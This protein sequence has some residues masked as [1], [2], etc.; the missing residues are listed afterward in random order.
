MFRRNHTID[1][2]GSMQNSVVTRGNDYLI[3][4]FILA[5]FYV[6]YRYPFKINDETQSSGYSE[7]PQFLKLGK[8]F[9]AGGILIFWSFYHMVTAPAHRTTMRN[10]LLAVLY[11][12]LAVCAVATSIATNEVRLGQVAVFLLIP[13]V[14]HLLDF[15]G[16]DVR[17]LY[18]LLRFVSVFALLFNVFIIVLY[19]TTG[20]LPALAYRGTVSIRFGSYLDDPNGFGIMLSCLIPFSWFAFRGIWKYLMVIGL[21]ASLPITQSLSGIIGTALAIIVFVSVRAMTN[22]TV[23]RI[24]LISGFAV[25]A[26]IVTVEWE[27]ITYDPMI[28]DLFR[29]KQG[30]MDVHRGDFDK[31]FEVKPAAWLGMDPTGELSETNYAE[32]LQ[33][34]GALFVL[35]AVG[36]RIYVGQRFAREM[37]RPDVP[38]YCLAVWSGLFCYIVCNLFGGFT[39]P[40]DRSFPTNMLLVL[41]TTVGTIGKFSYSTATSAEVTA[42]IAEPQLVRSRFSRRPYPGLVTR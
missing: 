39:L 7:T 11:G 34:Y 8:Y 22:P 9:L 33:N 3:W 14:A 29:Y 5:F 4:L 27:D 30:S 1:S 23:T 16:L 38:R 18:V 26:T 41:I 42:Q 40:I 25:I 21:M 36:L 15:P 35:I 37:L 13:F 32:N 17:K 10:V 19:E 24:L 2:D 6:I 12:Y 28:Q 20:R 31:L